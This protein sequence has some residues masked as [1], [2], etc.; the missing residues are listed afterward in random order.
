V[1]SGWHVVNATATAANTNI[2]LT[3]PAG[4]SS[5]TSYVCYGSD[6]TAKRSGAVVTFTYNSGTQFK[7]ALAG[8]GSAANNKVDIVCEG[9]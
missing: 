2:N 4:F 1:I 6:V 5:A 7:Y 9:H 3:A 8:S